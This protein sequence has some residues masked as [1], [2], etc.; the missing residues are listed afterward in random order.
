M[1]IS[2]LP[3]SSL[4]DICYPSTSYTANISHQE[5]DLRSRVKVIVDRMVYNA[6]SFFHPPAIL[7]V[8]LAEEDGKLEQKKLLERKSKS[9]EE[10][11]AEFYPIDQSKLTLAERIAESM[12]LTPS[13]DP[14]FRKKVDLYADPEFRKTQVRKYIDRRVKAEFPTPEEQKEDWFILAFCEEEFYPL[15]AQQTELFRR[16]IENDIWMINNHNRVALAK[17]KIN[18]DIL[19]PSE[20]AKAFVGKHKKCKAATGAVITAG[21]FF[22]YYHMVII[23][24]RY[25]QLSLL[26]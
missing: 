2:P 4:E 18:W 12:Q 11:R 24:S 15:Y 8:E 7:P 25:Q 20:K 13:S 22:L 19:S 14:E 16:Y 23:N 10:V 9:Y 17:H 3:S 1:S 26:R 21:C 5:S 6:Y